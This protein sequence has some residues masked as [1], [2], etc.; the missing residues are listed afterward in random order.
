MFKW[1]LPAG[2]PTTW[3]CW[4]DPS[5]DRRGV[6]SLGR[7]TGPARAV[8]GMARLARS[9]PLSLPLISSGL[10]APASPLTLG[11]TPPCHWRWRPPHRLFSTPRS[12][13]PSSLPL[14]SATPSSSLPLDSFL[15]HLTT[16]SAPAPAEEVSTAHVSGSGG[17][18]EVV[19]ARDEGGSVH[20]RR[21]R[22][23]SRG[24]GGGDELHGPAGPS[25]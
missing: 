8:H 13:S 6:P 10:W 9:T 24:D 12:V 16:A 5:M 17:A 25:D 3:D 18:E 15:V 22:R 21:Q 11:Q 14:L 7:H 1:I 19:T 23:M 20:R 2:Q 4:P